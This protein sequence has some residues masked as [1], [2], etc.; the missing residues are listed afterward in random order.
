MRQQPEPVVAMSAEAAMSAVL[1][2]VCSLLAILVVAALPGPLHAAERTPLLM[3]GKTALYQKVLIRP[4]AELSSTPGATG[5]AALQPFSVHFVYARQQFGGAPW[6]EIGVDRQGTVVGWIPEKKATV[7]KHAL[8][9]SFLNPAG[10]QRTLLM[11]SRV[12]LEAL[13][14]S[15]D[16]LVESESA[17]AAIDNGRAPDNPDVVSVE[18]KN[19]VDFR[20]QFYL[21]PIL[22]V[23]EVYPDA[24][25][26]M[27]LLK[28]A[29]VSVAEDEQ[30]S[31]PR[32]APSLNPQGEDFNASMTFVLDATTSMRPYIEAV[33]QAVRDI[34]RRMREAGI[35]GR[36]NFGLVAFRDST[37]AVP[38]LEYVARTYADPNETTSAD[39]FLAKIGG[40]RAATVPSKGFSEDAYSGLIHALDTIDWSGFHGRHLILIT[41]ASARE[42]YDSLSA[43]G[44][45]T[46]EMRNRLRE[47]GVYTYVMHLLTP[48]GANDHAQARN[49]YST[50]SRFGTS[51]SQ[52]LYYGIEAG[53]PDSLS[54]AVLRLSDEIIGHLTVER[55]EYEKEVE[56]RREALRNAKTHEELEQRRKELN[57]ALVGLA[58]KLQYFGER[59]DTTVPLVF[60]AWIADKDFRDQT[61]SA[62]DIR[63]LLTKNQ[64][65]DLREAMRRML[66]AAEVGQV[67]TDTF[68]TQLQAAAAAMGR[69]PDRIANAGTLAELGLIGEYMDDLPYRS[70]T[71][72]IRQEIWQQFTIGQQQE[73][74]DTVNSKLSLLE[75]MHDDTDKWV[76][77]SGRADA[78][79]AFYPV[80]LSALP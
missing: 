74:I 67:S 27:T 49:Q 16:L 30:Q 21:L 57:A 55:A 11:R 22:E 56:S 19:F 77:L 69:S 1:R 68:F 44:I 33:R 65:S 80:P 23:E 51:G 76:L 60:E 71:M 24:T 54:R 26:P 43:S 53:N 72:A 66:E 7:W 40:L 31:D 47:S 70:Q 61:L 14:N 62:I 79:E 32:A 25:D 78:G 4:G 5:G 45:M 17:L 50:V 2:L 39:T 13:L 42:G 36:L 29:S 41:D 48:A 9:A 10:R 59:E 64:L 35:D 73:F 6:I 37:D 12:S 38:G 63:L 8:T 46:G 20:N 3:E 15:E 52:N 75:D 58:I 34:H 28:V 18:P